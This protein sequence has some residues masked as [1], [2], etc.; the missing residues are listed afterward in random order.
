MGLATITALAFGMSM[1]AFAAALVRG[2]CARQLNGKHLFG[3][4]LLFG[5]VEMAMPLLGFALGSAAG[6]LV[7]SWDH[8]LAFIL[9]SVLGARMI[10]GAYGNTEDT[11]AENG[12]C[13]GTAAKI[14]K[15]SL[16]LLAAT[17]VGTS[18]DSLVAGVSLA[19]FDADIWT[20]AACI[21]LATTIMAALGM[22]LGHRFGSRFGAKAEI[23]GGLLLIAIG[24][25]VLAEHTGILG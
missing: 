11:P 2:S 3:T 23:F 8:W 24:T 9:L 22:W 7:G 5:I 6:G 10:Y 17:A 18:I 15:N 25:W 16:W 14:E 12:G 13:G 20:A 21:G 4:A 1:D 19:F